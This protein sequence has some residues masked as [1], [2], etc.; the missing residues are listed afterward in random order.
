MV[1]CLQ[2]S[3]A[4][5]SLGVVSLVLLIVA[6]MHNIPALLTTTLFII[7]LVI[8]AYFLVG[9]VYAG[10][11]AAVNDMCNNKDTI[12]MSL[13]VRDAMDLRGVVPLAE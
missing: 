8:I 3:V 4:V 1:F 6:M 9:L 2:A 10:A 7:N 12:A 11:L 5:F 13:A